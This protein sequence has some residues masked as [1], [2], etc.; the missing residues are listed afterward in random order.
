MKKILLIVLIVVLLAF[1]SIYFIIPGNI[2]LSVTAFGPCIPKNVNDCLANE[3]HWG[4]WWPEHEVKNFKYRLTQAFTDGAEIQVGRDGQDLKTRVFVLPAGKDSC[5][6]EWQAYVQTSFNPIKRI[7]RWLMSRELTQSMRVATDSLVSYAG[8]TENVYGF[9]I[10]RT[11]FTDTILLATRFSTATFPSTDLIYAAINSLKKKIK[12]EAA[13]EKDFPMLNVRQLDSNHFE[14]MIAICVDKML[15]NDGNFFVSMMVPMKDRFLKTAVVGGPQTV[16]DAH[17]AIESY[18]SDRVLTPPAIPFEI[19]ITDRRKERDTS[20][21][22][23]VIFHPS[24]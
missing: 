18:M 7:T 2:R 5:I 9:H 12:N 21:W 16:K 10:E 3:G 8:K 14:T 1:T 20:K 17:Q 24:M 23:T 22:K 13:K 15:T 6:V 19:L 4:K 11:T